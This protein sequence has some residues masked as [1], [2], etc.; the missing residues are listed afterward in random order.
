[1]SSTVEWWALSRT[2]LSHCMH[3][4]WARSKQ[5]KSLCG[6]REVQKVKPFTYRI[7]EIDGCSKR[8]IF[9][10]EW[11]HW[12]PTHALV[13]DPVFLCIQTVLSGLN[14]LKK[15]H[16]KLEEKSS[17]RGKGKNLKSVGMGNRFDQN[18]PYTCMKLLNLH[19]IKIVNYL[20]INLHTSQS[21]ISWTV[22]SGANNQNLLLICQI[23][24]T[25]SRTRESPC[26][27]GIYSLVCH[28]YNLMVKRNTKI[29]SSKCHGK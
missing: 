2:S 13:D 6:C 24:Y 20:M 27:W 26:H 29:N 1:M 7:L 16:E 11:S 28:T 21:S 15:E 5:P 25:I 4:T 10:Q 19:I 14:T 17:C 23:R 9:L 3:K 8:V 12:E 22:C 18:I